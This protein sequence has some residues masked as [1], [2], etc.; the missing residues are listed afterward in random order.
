MCGSFL[1]IQEDNVYVIYEL[2]R[3][4]LSKEVRHDIFPCGTGD[5]Y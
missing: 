3:D 4:F 5:V 1:I 2:A